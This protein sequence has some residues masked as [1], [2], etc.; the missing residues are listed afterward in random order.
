[1]EFENRYLKYFEYKNLGGKPLDT[2][3]NLLEY[4]AEK[5]VDE[6]TFNRFS[7]LSSEQ[8][9]DELKLCIYELIEILSEEGSSVI[10]SETVGS[11]SVSVQSKTNIEKQK[12]NIIRQYLSNTKVNGV[13][14]LY[15]G[16][17]LYEN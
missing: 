14:V 1:M 2:P 16:A 8:Y 9:P 5:K 6:L 4:K 15:R 3:F 17:D 11:Y 12:E 7:K 13:F 10:S